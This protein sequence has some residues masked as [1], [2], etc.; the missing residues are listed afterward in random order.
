MGRS[1]RN[2]FFRISKPPMILPAYAPVDNA[3]HPFRGI[4]KY[5]H[6]HCTEKFLGMHPLF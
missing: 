1:G 5:L 2:G 6:A 3:L 4:F